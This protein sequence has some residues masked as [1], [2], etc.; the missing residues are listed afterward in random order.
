M[1]LK[2]IF[3]YYGNPNRTLESHSSSLD[4]LASI[5]WFIVKNNLNKNSTSKL[6]LKSM[7]DLVRL[8]IKYHFLED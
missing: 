8:A 7:I 6:C 1:Y 3:H 5:L 4:Y 2:H